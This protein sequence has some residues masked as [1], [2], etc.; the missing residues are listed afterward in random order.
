MDPVRVGR[1]WTSGENSSDF[2]VG[3]EN[4]QDRE[5][6]VNASC[7]IEVGFAWHEPGRH[8]A[9][10]EVE[11]DGGLFHLPLSGESYQLR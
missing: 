4:C 3:R 1:V 5:L 2:V 11:T 7:S 10:L 8:L 9:S 6:E